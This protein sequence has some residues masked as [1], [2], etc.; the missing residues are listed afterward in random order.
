MDKLRYELTLH[1]GDYEH[2]L[3][4]TG[5]WGKLALEYQ[6]DPVVDIF[7]RMISDRSYDACEMS[8]SN[9][10]MLRARGEQWLCALPIFPYRAFRHSAV[11]VAAN[12]NLNDPRQLEGLRLGVPDYAM[13]AAVWVRGILY[14]HYGVDWRSIE[15]FT[16]GSRMPLPP[17]IEVRAATGDLLDELISGRLDAL[18]L[19]SGPK[20][21]LGVNEIPPVRRLFPDVTQVER[22]YFLSTGIHPIMHTVVVKTD[23]LDT[24]PELSE[25]LFKAY[26]SSKQVAFSRRLSRS[27]LPWGRVAWDEIDQ[28]FQGDPLPYGLTSNNIRTLKKLGDYLLAQRL[29]QRP[30]DLASMFALGSEGLV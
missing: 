17:S 27:T 19:P 21:S 13:T 20:Q 25:M 16:S 12:S 11:Y 15:W 26:S 7:R 23:K 4:L 10:M 28:L 3:S 9:Y 5:R 2:T 24:V 29:I 1:G 30:V 22:E 6:T 14:E 8:L 18:I